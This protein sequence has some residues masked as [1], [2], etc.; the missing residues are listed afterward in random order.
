MFFENGWCRFPHDPVLATWVDHALPAARTAVTA[1]QYAE[2]VRC[3]GTWFVG[4]NALPNGPDGVVGGGPALSGQAVDFIHGD[5]GL[6]GFDWD[7]AQI[8]V[9]YPG[10]PKPMDGDSDA[11]FAFRRD[12]DAAHVDGVRRHEPDRRRFLLEHHGFI[13]GIPMVSSSADASPLAIWE[14]SHHMVREAFR[15]VLAEIPPDQWSEIDITEAYHAVRREIFG[16]CNRVTVP[17]RPG[18]AYLI[19]RLALHGVAPWSTTAEAGP[20][21]RMIAYFRPETGKSEDWIFAP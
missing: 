9:C 21:G 7:R 11:N 16:T 4:V 6:S 2:W 18:E 1:P 10:Y 19:H 3:D 5:L 12:R 14:G 13:L 20:D 17:A 8:S 15:V